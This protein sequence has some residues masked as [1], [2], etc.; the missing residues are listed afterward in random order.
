MNE[1]A[2]FV[3]EILATPRD[4]APRLAFVDWLEGR[5]DPRGECLRVLL[6][7]EALSE[8]E[9][10][11]GMKAKLAWVREIAMLRQRLREL[12]ER[13]PL[14]WALRLTR[15]WIEH[16]NMVGFGVKCPRRWE[17]MPETDEP[18]VRRCGHC[19]RDVWFCWSA[20]DVHEA[21]CSGHPVVKALAMDRA[22]PG[23]TAVGGRDPGSL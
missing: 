8:K 17:L 2:A 11:P 15:G 20:S 12:R 7:L 5:G 21:L 10:P 6:R 9:A 1:E 14:A 3:A 22:E 13:V 18:E 19:S 4:D 23:T 16:C